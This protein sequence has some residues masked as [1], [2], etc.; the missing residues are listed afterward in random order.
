MYQHILAPIDVS[1]PAIGEQILD[2]ALFHLR[3][4]D[5]QITL[6][7]VAPMK[8]DEASVDEIRGKLMD[9][10]EHQIKANEGRIHLKVS[11]GLPSDEVLSTAKALNAD[12][13]FIGRHRGEHSQLGR[14]TLGST[15]AKICSQADADVL[16]VKAG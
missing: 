10:A 1:V 15:A 14:P 11:Q 5:T 2:K 16:V 3:Y 9:F 6:L 12:A 13:I 4:A 8:A 7:A